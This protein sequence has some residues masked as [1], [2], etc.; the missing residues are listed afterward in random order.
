M[1]KKRYTTIIMLLT[2]SLAAFSLSP[3]VNV[4]N[5]EDVK[6]DITIKTVLFDFISSQYKLAVG[7]DMPQDRL[8]LL[9]SS[10][11]EASKIF[12]ISP[13]MIAAIIDTETNFK[14]I[15]GSYGEVGYMQLRP[16]T[17]QFVVNKYYD[18]FASLNYTET[19][20]DWIE[21]RLLLDPRYNILVGTAYLKYL[22]ETHGD[23][24]KA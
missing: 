18:L 14:N 21:E 5:Q 15:I 13:L 4:N 6:E 7:K 1:H 20:L 16:S 9:V 8:Q 22:M 23:P 17:A 24:Y 12:E 3:Y 2:L 11:M 10:I 19:S